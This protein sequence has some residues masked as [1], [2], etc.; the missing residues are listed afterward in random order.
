MMELAR[1]T[2]VNPPMPQVSPDD[3]VPPTTGFA[4]TEP[5]AALD[6]MKSLTR[7]ANRIQREEIL[8]AQTFLH[9]FYGIEHAPVI[10]PE[11]QQMINI[12]KQ[13]APGHDFIHNFL[14]ILSR[15]HYMATTRSSECIVASDVAHVDLEECCRGIVYMQLMEIDE[16]RHL[17][18]EQYGICDYQTLTGIKGRHSGQE[19]TG[20]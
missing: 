2:L 16:M 10:T 18:C 1:G 20:A 7:Q 6:E 12:L 5:K 9:D 15:H 19:P 11:N 4:P 17:L 14:E 8:Q 3:R 13:A